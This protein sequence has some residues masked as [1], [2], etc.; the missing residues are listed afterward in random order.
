MR[1]LFSLFVALLAI[2]NLHAYNFKSGDLFYTI[3]SDSTVE[4]ASPNNQNYLTI[5]SLTIP[6]AVE[7]NGTLYYITRIGEAAFYNCT[8]LQSITIPENIASVGKN[9][10]SWCTSLT[11]VVWNSV[12]CEDF[13]PKDNSGYSI[14]PFPA[15]IASQITSFILGEKVKN[16]PAY[17][18][19]KMKN[20]TKLILPETLSYIGSY[21]FADCSNLYTINIPQSISYVG[22]NAFKG[23]YWYES[24]QPDGLVYINNILYTYKGEMPNN[25]S[26]VIDE[27]TKS[28][29]PCA[30]LSCNSLENITIPNT[31]ISIEHQAFENCSS[32]KSITIPNKLKRIEYRTFQ[33]CY[34]LSEVVIPRSV[35]SIGWQAFGG[36][37]SLIS[38]SI[39][40]SVIEIEKFA[41]YECRRLPQIE[42]PNSVKTIGNCAFAWC[43]KLENVKLGNGLS[44]IE[45]GTF[46]YCY[47]LK[48]IDLPINI[49][50][51]GEAAFSKC[52]NLTSLSIPSDVTNIDNSAFRDCSSLVSIEIPNSVRTIG[53]YAFDGCKSLVSIFIPD[54]VSKIERNV[55]SNCESLS[56]ISIPN[57]I[58]EIGEEAFYRCKSLSE[59]TIPSALETLGNKAFGYCSSLIFLTLPNT[60]TSIGVDC[61]KGCSALRK[62]N[63]VGELL[64]WTQIKFGNL[65]ANPIYYSNKLYLNNRR[66]SDLVIT[67]EIEIV[68]DY[69]FNSDSAF[70]SITS[71]AL[72]PPTLGYQVFASHLKNDGV[73]YILDESFEEYLFSDWKDSFKHIKPIAAQTVDTNK[74]IIEAGVNDVKITWPID[75]M[76]D[77]Y[78]ITINN[79]E[80]IFC[81]LNFNSEGVLLNVTYILARDGYSH[82]S[83]SATVT[84]GGF[85]FTITNLNE[86]T[87]YTYEISSKDLYDGILSSYEGEFSTHYDIPT[88]INNLTVSKDIQ[89]SISNG[90]VVIDKDGKQYT[91]MGQEI[92]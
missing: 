62:T 55:F 64:G 61:F 76:A 5:S 81:E 22:D 67:D 65:Y 63:Y 49:T 91:I 79:N 68:G 83:K 59:I 2:T 26:I 54:G 48:S 70:S 35:T 9:A 19:Y 8:S 25:A 42:I 92:K 69:V 20:I 15:S 73:V 4:V 84:G 87:W 40:D 1:K 12:S 60:L 28:I 10:F 14:L 51:I 43:E 78:T 89:K 30:F 34:S 77:K 57:G 24:I 53:M 82:S 47:Q 23:T 41:F 37:S 21:A 90:Q 52:T 31:V 44:T 58:T 18:C 74:I 36:C 72:T 6:D 11:H 27:G 33:G 50:S 45:N 56:S 32:L 13:I 38:I 71:L 80:N 17:L 16:I 86:D 3:T 66:I 39:P 46:E 75:S 88:L 7:H 29:S 85:C